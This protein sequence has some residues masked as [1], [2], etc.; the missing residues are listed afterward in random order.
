MAVEVAVEVEVGT[1]GTR[2]EPKAA[3][4]EEDEARV[5]EPIEK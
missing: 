2:Q 1:A 5:L 3:E 4:V